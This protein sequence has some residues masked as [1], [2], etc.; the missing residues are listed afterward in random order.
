MT[1]TE[2]KA[3]ARPW[4]V[5]KKELMR[6]G[7]DAFKIQNEN[8]EETICVM[9]NVDNDI[10]KTNAKLIVKAVNL[11]DELITIL[12]KLPD[13]LKGIPT[14]YGFDDFLIDEIESVLTKA[15]A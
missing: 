2:D 3:T 1:K 5:T 9:S 10:A 8:T 15:R 12:S 14:M 7:F 13:L 6:T 4:E 11:H